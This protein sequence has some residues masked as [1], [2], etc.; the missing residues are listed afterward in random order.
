VKGW[1]VITQELCPREVPDA[2][3][4]PI[5]LMEVVPVSS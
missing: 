4:Y 2:I 5:L 1:L 3:L